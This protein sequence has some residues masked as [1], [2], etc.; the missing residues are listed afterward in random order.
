MSWRQ[1]EECEQEQHERAHPPP[2][3]DEWYARMQAG[4]Q[5][6]REIREQMNQEGWNKWQH[7]QK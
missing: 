1:Q 6:L 4:E 5:E 3:S 2:F 7:Q